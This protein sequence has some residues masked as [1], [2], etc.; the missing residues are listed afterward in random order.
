MTAAMANLGARSG[1]LQP[2]VKT[3]IIEDE[4]L[5]RTLLAQALSVYP[6]IHVVAT[7]ADGPSALDEIPALEPD[8]AVVDIQLPGGINGIQLGLR[9][10][11][12]LPH[13]GIVLLSNYREP[14]FLSS[15]SPSE[16]AGWSYLLKRSVGDISTV[17]RAI[18]GSV[19]GE[20]VI[21]PH[22]TQDE[23]VWA[24][25]VLGGLSA[26]EF[27]ILRLIA[28]GYSNTAIAEKLVL[29]LRTVENRIRHLYQRMGIDT[30]SPALQPRVLAVLRYLEA[31][32]MFH[33]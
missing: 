15:L 28:Q 7:Y 22:L 25:G 29:S 12:E 20:V 14:G 26:R 33:S 8:V 17:Y 6:D 21:D 30:T 31:L 1:P 5:F 9:L 11:Q 27:E 13:L 23:R 24:S 18:K 32:E 3:V 2:P 16:A 19:R 10:R 4:G